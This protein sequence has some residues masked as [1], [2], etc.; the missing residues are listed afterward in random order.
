M[1]EI[2]V[3]WTG[4]YPCLC[5]GEWKLTIDGKDVSETI[6]FQNED[7]GTHGQYSFW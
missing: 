3:E 6:P 7:A 5:F 2:K 4:V 1:K